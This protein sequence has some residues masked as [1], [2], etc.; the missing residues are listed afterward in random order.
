MREQYLRE[1]DAKIDKLLLLKAE[2]ENPGVKY[3]MELIEEKKAMNQK[4][5]RG[6]ND[7]QELG[8]IQGYDNLAEELLTFIKF[9]E[10]TSEVDLRDNPK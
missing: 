3:F 5:Y 4:M 9:V 1:E 6:A 10:S 7:L 2:L 8:K